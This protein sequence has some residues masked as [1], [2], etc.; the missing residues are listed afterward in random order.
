ML[1]Q[2]LTAIMPILYL[3]FSQRCQH[4]MLTACL[5]VRG[6]PSRMKPDSP[7][8]SASSRRLDNSL[9]MVSSEINFPWLTISASCKPE[10]D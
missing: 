1:Y 3:C 9:I 6:K 10:N 4:K 2:S 8:A 7:L 5:K